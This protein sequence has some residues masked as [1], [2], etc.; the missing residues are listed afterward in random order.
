MI[1]LMPC[2]DL[3]ERRLGATIS[4][5]R[6]QPRLSRAAAEERISAQLCY[7]VISSRFDVRP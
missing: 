2:I 5:C 7:V 4:A 6:S 1:M 3:A